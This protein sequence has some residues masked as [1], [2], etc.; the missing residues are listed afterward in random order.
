MG[1]HTIVVSNARIQIELAVHKLT[2]L[3]LELGLEGMSFE[4]DLLGCGVEGRHFDWFCWR[5]KVCVLGV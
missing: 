1:R 5:Y 2:P 4:A 3:V